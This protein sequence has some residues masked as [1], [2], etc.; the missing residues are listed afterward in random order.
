M[1]RSGDLVATKR[2]VADWQS[3]ASAARP[4]VQFC[5]RGS[6]TEDY[7]PCHVTQ[8]LAASTLKARDYDLNIPSPSVEELLEHNT[9]KT[10]L[11]IPRSVWGG[12]KDNAAL[13]ATPYY[14]HIDLHSDGRILI[15]YW[16]FFAYNGDL[17]LIF[18]IPLVGEH[19][20][21]WEHLDVLL[22]DDGSPTGD[23]YFAAHGSEGDWSRDFDRNA[24]GRPITYSAWHSHA[25]YARKGKHSRYSSTGGFIPDFAFGGTPWNGPVEMVSINPDLLVDPKSFEEAR[26]LAWLGD[27]G[28]TDGEFTSSPSGPATAGGWNPTKGGTFSGWI[29]FGSGNRADLTQIVAGTSGDRQLHVVSLSNDLPYPLVSHQSSKAPGGWTEWAAMPGW[30]A[31]GRALRI[32]SCYTYPGLLLLVVEMSE[33]YFLFCE[34]TIDSNGINWRTW[35]ETSLQLPPNSITWTVV[36]DKDYCAHILVATDTGLFDY[37]QLTRNDLSA[38]ESPVQI[39]SGPK[40]F[41]TATTRGDGSI[42]VAFGRDADVQMRIY[43]SK[44]YD[45]IGISPESIPKLIVSRNDTLTMF[46]IGPDNSVMTCSCSQGDPSTWGPWMQLGVISQVSHLDYAL[47]GDGRICLFAATSPPGSNGEILMIREKARYDGWHQW[48]KNFTLQRTLTVLALA[49]NSDNRLEA[50]ALVENKLLHSF[51]TAPYEN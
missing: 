36:P 41:I 31:R 33:G 34:Q 22:N 23:V 43:L 6:H 7:F 2:T 51:E 47:E 17:G 50:F 28:S 20:G 30:Q 46:G 11:D 26:W 19:E 21:D 44:W 37:K 32:Q 13:N 29:P 45:P 9:K 12:N 14:T 38:W 3:I 48:E 25:S 8:V 15:Q 5:D 27:W 24:E 39:A 1:P 35:T 10:Y 42:A 16:F 4:E 49:A 18:P 40:S